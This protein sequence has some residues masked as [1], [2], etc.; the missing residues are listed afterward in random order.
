MPIHTEKRVLPYRPEQIFALVADVEK[1]PEFLPWCVACRKTKTFDDGF[2]ADLAIGFKMVREKF[3]SRVTLNKPDR[4]EV[5][6][7]KGPFSTLSNIWRFTPVKDGDQTE[8]NFS[9]D[10]EFR[11]RV[12]QKLIGVLFEEAVRRMVAAFEARARDLYGSS[13]TD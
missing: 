2:E 3:T 10:F 12:I 13:E 5:A 7:L 8:I 6:Y 4:I 9:L 11:S 1:Y